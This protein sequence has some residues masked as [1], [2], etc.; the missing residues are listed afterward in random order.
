[1]LFIS[2]TYQADE[3]EQ[4]FLPTGSGTTSS[5]RHAERLLTKGFG[6]ES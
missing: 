5:G 3:T 6:L 4:V 2:L 1:L